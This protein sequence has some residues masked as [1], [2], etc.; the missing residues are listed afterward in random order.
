[1][2]VRRFP[3][4]SL[5]R[6]DLLCAA[7][8]ALIAVVL[9][10][11][12][13]AHSGSSTGAVVTVTQDGAVIRQIPLDSDSTVEVTVTGDYTNVITVGRGEAAFSSSDCPGEDCVH[14]GK[15]TRPG[16][17]AACLPNRVS[18]TVTGGGSD[19]PDVIIG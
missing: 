1:M 18:V 14:S 12:L 8:I 6:G 3:Q 19:A 4:C 7:L 17:T 9:G 15:L 2:P 13:L 5:R 16:Q 11:F 10:A